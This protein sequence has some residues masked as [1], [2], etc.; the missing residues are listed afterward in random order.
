MEEL[1]KELDRILVLAPQRI[2]LSAPR[3]ERAD[4]RRANLRLLEQGWQLEVLTLTQAFHETIQAEKLPAR[5]EALLRE[6]FQQLTA[7]TAQWELR[8][9]LTRKG[10]V[11]ASQTR[12]TKQAK[13]T[14]LEHDRGKNY[15]LP[16]GE[17][18]LPLV[19]MG[20]LTPDGRVVRSMYDKFRQVN[21]FV[22]LVDDE[23]AEMKENRIRVIDYGCGKSYLT[24][25]L[26]HYLAHVR[27]LDVEMTGLDL[28][29]DVVEKCN[30]TAKKYHYGGLHFETGDIAGHEEAGPVDLV[31]TLHACDTATDQAL[32]K[33]VSWGAEMIFSVPCC[34][35]ELCAQMQGGPL[36]ILSRYGIVK[37]R[38]AALMT[39]AIRTNLLE[40]SGYRTQLLEF[41]D[42]AHTPKNLL[43]RARRAAIPA[44]HRRKML[45]EVQALNAAFSFSP[46]LLDLLGSLGSSGAWGVLGVLGEEDKE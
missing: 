29:Q 33:A 30:E 23:L 40:A 39:D 7:F 34:Q 38:T 9:K 22:Q 8:L 44:A 21:R 42:L 35:H 17:P 4:L 46:A 36:P 3:K 37:E 43:I 15:L 12:A 27:G 28:K 13:P 18:V 19:D 16:E 20:V 31:V 32:A 14:G 2:I 41:I 1:K 6:D 5:L 25:V 11:L 10:K 45:E 24:F 26:Y